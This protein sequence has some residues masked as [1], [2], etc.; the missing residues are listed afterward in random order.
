MNQAFNKKMA[1]TSKTHEAMNSFDL[2]ILEDNDGLFIKYKDGSSLELSPCGAVFLHRQMT[3]KSFKMK[4]L[5][6]FAV[7]SYR[8]KVSE[9]LRI[10]NYHAKRPYLCRELTETEEMKVGYHGIQYCHWPTQPTLDFI[11]RLPNGSTQVL[12]L[13]GFAS[14]TLLPHKQLFIKGA[15]ERQERQQKTYFV[16]QEQIH[17]S[18]SHPEEWSYPLQLLLKAVNITGAHPVTSPSKSNNSVTELPQSLPVTCHASHHHT[19]R[20]SQVQN[21]SANLEI[22]WKPN[23]KLIWKDGTIFRFFHQV[24]PPSCEV[25][26]EDGSLMRSQVPNGKYFNHWFVQK[27][28]QQSALIL[29]R[30]YSAD[31]PPLDRFLKKE[32]SVSKLLKQ[33]VSFMEY[34]DNAG[35]HLPESCCWQ[36]ASVTLPK[37]TSPAELVETAH[38]PGTGRFKAFSNGNINVVFCDRTILDLQKATDDKENGYSC[39]LVLPNGAMEYFQLTDQKQCAI[40][41][42]YLQAAYH[43]REWFEA[44]P[45][46]RKTFYEGTIWDPSKRGAVTTELEKIKR[47][48]YMN[49]QQCQ[50]VDVPLEE[51]QNTN[52]AARQSKNLEDDKALTQLCC[53]QDREAIINS[54]LKQ[55]CQVIVDIDGLV[56]SFKSSLKKSSCT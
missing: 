53:S 16:W 27:N 2:L 42:K 34:L 13:D 54:I 49:S 50:F 3:P 32:Y 20:S 6:R 33:A 45:L 17:S 14:L 24:F 18:F 35:Q 51:V 46:Q 39:Q 31:K 22:L 30:V 41:H 37:P 56:S 29:E 47:F 10:R 12:S 43:W 52:I 21:E 15:G 26:L 1:A 5:T 9:A 40:Y 48:K 55:N 4:Q 28:E 23:I 44:S 11:T 36:K 25:I 19:W 8:N 7:S 38:V